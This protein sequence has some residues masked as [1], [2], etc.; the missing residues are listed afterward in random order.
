M[1]APLLLAA[2]GGA[3]CA[4][5]GLFNVA[6]EGLMLMGAFFG[7]AGDHFTGSPWLGVL[8]AVVVSAAFSLILAFLTLHWRANEIVVGIALN[9]LAL[10]LTTFLL[11]SVLGATGAFYD[12]AMRGL[13]IWTLAGLQRVPVLGWLFG[14]TPLVYLAF[15]AAVAMHLFL[16]RTVPGFR[17]RA[18]GINPEAA[19]SVGIRPARAQY[20][21][22]VVSGVLC[23]L[24]GAQLS[25]GDLTMFSQGMTAGRGFIALVAMML[26]RS[27]PLG[28][29]LA[30]ALF[31]LTDAIGI[32]LQGFMPTQFAL[33]V[34]YV[35][36]VIAMFFFRDKYLRP[37]ASRG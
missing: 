27:N 13:P 32:R 7:V 23:G 26:G 19:A 1:M 34:P 8:W 36:T 16:F 35:V 2:L 17:F 22:V 18:V 21:A 30:S 3:L 15:A 37:L 12:P 20:V 4:R 6:L 33:M 10:A 31:G 25:V 9:F 29:I 11:R 14:Y 5:V 28:V 24:A